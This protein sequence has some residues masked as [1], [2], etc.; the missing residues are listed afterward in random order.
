MNL[1]WGLMLMRA[2]SN[3]YSPGI[4]WGTGEAARL[5]PILTMSYS[6][7]WWLKDV[8]CPFSQTHPCFPSSFSVLPLFI[9][10]RGGTAE[11]NTRSFSSGRG[12]C[13]HIFWSLP[14]APACAYLTVAVNIYIPVS[15]RGGHTGASRAIG[16][17]V[18]NDSIPSFSPLCRSDSLQL[19]RIHCIWWRYNAASGA[20]LI[21]NKVAQ[22]SVFC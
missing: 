16:Y 9:P 6:T 3:C 5:W 10:Q 20:E 7:C 1:F 22:T 8:F 11:N 17:T 18:V 15:L 2:A 13:A 19:E 4:V 12:M 14:L 21:T